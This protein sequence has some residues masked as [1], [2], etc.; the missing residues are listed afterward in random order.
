[1]KSMEPLQYVKAEDRVERSGGGQHGDGL[2]MDS[3]AGIWRNTNSETR[4]IVKVEIAVRG[5]R[6]IV[7]AV[8][9]GEVD[10]SDWGEVEAE[11]IFANNISSHVA[12]GFTAQ[13]HFDFS[14]VHLQANWNQG[15]LVLASFMSFKDGS[16]R[17]NYFSREFFHR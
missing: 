17:S 9:A 15:L 16:N 10:T 13:Y 14:Q 1:M 11:H 4:G 12:A 2:L 8:G 7:H 6:L 5:S 3:L